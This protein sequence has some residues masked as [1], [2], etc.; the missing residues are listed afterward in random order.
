MHPVF[1]LLLTLLSPTLT[2]PAGNSPLVAVGPRSH[3]TNSV[4]SPQKLSCVYRGKDSVTVT[5]QFRRN[6]PGH[7]PDNI[8]TFARGNVTMQPNFGGLKITGDAEDS[9]LFLSSLGPQDSGVYIC[10]FNTFG[11]GSQ[12]GEIKLTVV[13]HTDIEVTRGPF[14]GCDNLYPVALTVSGVPPPRLRVFPTHV[15]DGESLSTSVNG[16]GVS[17]VRRTVFVNLTVASDMHAHH[18]V[19]LADYD[20]TNSQNVW[21]SIKYAS[22]CFRRVRRQLDDKIVRHNPT[23]FPPTTREE[24]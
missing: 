14:Q 1:I 10:L 13:N 18:L 12:K 15:L 22:S 11:L 9:H 23:P 4:N 19:G 7:V 16:K 17:T 8:G 3:V 20:E 24:L 2:A 5:W 6:T 21:I